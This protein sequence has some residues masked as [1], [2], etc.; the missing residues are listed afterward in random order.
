[1]LVHQTYLFLSNET[2]NDVKFVSVLLR[3]LVFILLQLVTDLKFV[4]YWSDFPTS[5][6]RRKTIFK[7][8]SSHQE[9]FNVPVS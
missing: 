7:L 3:K 6:Y 2:Q 4:H 1:M 8:V 5:L 9:Y